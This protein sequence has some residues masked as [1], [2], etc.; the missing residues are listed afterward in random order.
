MG[1]KIYLT[2]VKVT[3]LRAGRGNN[4]TLPFSMLLVCRINYIE[5]V[6]NEKHRAIKAKRLRKKQKPG[7]L[8]KFLGHSVQQKKSFASEKRLPILGWEILE[9][10]PPK[11]QNKL[12]R[13]YFS[14]QKLLLIEAAIFALFILYLM[15]L[16]LFPRK[17]GEFS[18]H[19]TKKGAEIGV[20]SQWST[21][22]PAK[23]LPAN[24]VPIINTENFTG[25]TEND[26]VKSSVVNNL[27]LHKAGKHDALTE[28]KDVLSDTSPH[29]RLTVSKLKNFT[30]KY[31][32][33][34]IIT[35]RASDSLMAHYRPKIEFSLTASGVP[36]ANEIIGMKLS[37]L[38]RSASTITLTVNDIIEKEKA[39]I[40]K[41]AQGL[42]LT[43]VYEPLLEKGEQL[44]QKA[45]ANHD[46]ETASV[47]DAA[48]YH[49][50][51]ILKVIK[52]RFIMQAEQGRAEVGL[53][54][55]Q[56]LNNK[57]AFSEKYTDTIFD[58][59]V[60][61][62]IAKENISLYRKRIKSEGKK[63][64]Q[65]VVNLHNA[66][67][68]EAVA[69]LKTQERTIDELPSFSENVLRLGNG[70]DRY[71][72]DSMDVWASQAS[73][74]ALNCLR[75]QANNLPPETR[76]IIE[77]FGDNNWSKSALIQQM[78]QIDH[79]EY[80]SRNTSS[81]RAAYEILTNAINRQIDINV[82]RYPTALGPEW[83]EHISGPAARAA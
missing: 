68:S 34:A 38:H 41:K 64:P 35:A 50:Q 54:K 5:V 72:N 67:N 43:A 30:I 28:S 42:A 9:D 81:P 52:E 70:L 32:C 10:V 78:S 13:V 53:L 61:N 14:K 15:R 27:D 25:F 77:N 26:D 37:G 80:R 12:N 75:R 71:I 33:T 16:E 60:I 56:L 47:H 57:T 79:L 22:K 82:T 51:N 49:T 65:H 18:R 76:Q 48:I 74:N 46:I 73:K 44:Y 63:F 19:P 20:V 69:H 66:D 39:I 31:G 23:R 58:I 36:S 24:E 29:S 40:S 62:H 2:K 55:N 45:I 8:E 59:T 3:S 6:E 1:G 83:P 17:I 21:E 4:E 7:L 11:G